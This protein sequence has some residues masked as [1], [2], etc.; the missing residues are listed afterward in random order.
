[1]RKIFRAV[2]AAFFMMLILSCTFAGSNA[3]DECAYHNFIDGRC[4]NCNAYYIERGTTVK[5]ILE[6]KGPRLSGVAWTVPTGGCVQVVEKGVDGLFEAT[7]YYAIVEGLK[8]GDGEV[9]AYSKGVLEQTAKVYVDCTKHVYGT[10]ISD[11]NASCED[12]TKTA[13]CQYCDNTNTVTDMG[14]AVH[15][16]LNYTPNGDATCSKDGTKT[17]VCSKCG[18]SVTVADENSQLS[19]DYRDY[20]SDGNATCKLDGTKTGVCVNCG[21]KDTVTDKGS[22]T[23]H[24]FGEY[25]SDNNA[26]CTEDGTLT[27]R[28]EK[29]SEPDSKVDL[30][31]R[32]GHSYGEWIIVTEMNCL[33]DGLREKFC[34][35]CGLK[36]SEV[37]TKSGHSL[38]YQ[39]E[40]APTCKEEGRTSGWYCK[41]A[42]CPTEYEGSEPIP[43]T[44]H[45]IHTSKGPASTTDNGFVMVTCSYCDEVFDSTVIYR[46]RSVALSETSYNYDGKMKTP[47][48]IVTDVDDQVLTEGED[49]TVKFAGTRKT[50]G[51]YTVKII[52]EGDYEGTETRSFVIKPVKP[53]KLEATQTTD[54]I[55]LKWSKAVGATGYRVYVYNSKTGKYKTVK[56]TAGTVCTVKE[57]KSGTTYKYA[58][59]PYT[60]A[61]DGEIIWAEESVKLTTATK[62]ATLKVKATVGSKKVTLKWNEVRG[63]K[64]YQVYMK[65]PD[66]SGYKKIKVT[67]AESYT[68]KSLK[69]GATYSF[70]VRAYSKVDGKYIY[71]GYKTY[72]VKVK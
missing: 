72:T 48:V 2:T 8:E 70:R 26:T 39:A 60:E 51:K 35:R 45:S 12:G 19:H 40:R 49:Y 53:E 24:S 65:G 59:K 44:E 3:A 32:Y 58:V 7:T 52:F 22:A 4:T 21:A 63:A 20:V 55:T 25:I 28:C 36:Q 31:S 14:S 18:L 34:E 11:N 16:V 56:T 17:G 42:Y 54:T 68:V 71:G 15:Q 66:D 37:V 41:N 38:V 69:K 61:A 5:I 13:K 50:P 29:C 47:S 57:L 1:M 9:Y 62:P 10:Y 27:A 23:G 6:E 64:G 30:Y 43:K 33:Q 46:I 67:T